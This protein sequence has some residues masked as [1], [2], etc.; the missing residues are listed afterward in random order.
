MDISNQI[1]LTATSTA[2]A[3]M[4]AAIE[5]RKM[6]V[7]IKKAL[8]DLRLPID[9][10]IPCFGDNS[11][12][13]AL[14]QKDHPS[15]KQRHWLTRAEWTQQLVDMGIVSFHKIASVNN[16]SDVSTKITPYFTFESLSRMTVGAPPKHIPGTNVNIRLARDYAR[17]EREA[18]AILTDRQPVVT[19]E[20]LEE[21]QGSAHDSTE[22]PNSALRGSYTGKQACT[23]EGASRMPVH[24]P[25]RRSCGVR[26][27]QQSAH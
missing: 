23:N 5:A 12:Q 2:E 16:A 19:E 13:I 27:R 14:S 4:C 10:R 1:K 26:A 6:A 17:K 7:Y 3:E 20:L 22:T 11:A 25:G 24:L 9:G 15:R 21:P 8:A 18:G